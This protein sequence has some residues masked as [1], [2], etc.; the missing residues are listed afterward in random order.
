[1]AE[2]I[3]TIEIQISRQKNLKRQGRL[4]QTNK[5]TY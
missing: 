3:F 5:Q 1:L 4:E 2:E